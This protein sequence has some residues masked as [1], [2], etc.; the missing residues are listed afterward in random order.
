M[1]KAEW[2]DNEWHFKFRTK[3]FSILKPLTLPAYRI[4]L[5]LWNIAYFEEDFNN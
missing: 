2:K 3:H 4:F 5:T 1:K